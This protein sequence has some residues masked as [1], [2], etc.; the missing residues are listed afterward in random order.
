ME[1][2]SKLTHSQGADCGGSWRKLLIKIVE[3]FE[4]TLCMIMLGG[5]WDANDAT[6]NLSGYE[7]P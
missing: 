7:I 6:L 4:V 5:K 1:L 2:Y 3:M